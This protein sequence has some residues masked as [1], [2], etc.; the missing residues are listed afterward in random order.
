M[1]RLTKV[2]QQ[3]GKKK[4][5]VVGMTED[6]EK[7][8]IVAVVKRLKEYEDTGLEPL[9]IKSLLVKQTNYGCK[10]CERYEYMEFFVRNPNG[11]VIRTAGNIPAGGKCKFC[12]NCGRK[13]R[14]T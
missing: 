5:C 1:E 4:L 2:R 11:V 8:K 12:P 6:N 9:E 10:W 13:L 7:S 14:G 3:D